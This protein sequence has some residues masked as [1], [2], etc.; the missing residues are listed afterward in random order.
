MEN[1]ADPSRKSPE[2]KN[3]P[4]SNNLVWYALAA[5]VVVLLLVGWL[6]QHT[7]N[8]LIYSDLVALIDASGPGPDARGYIDVQE[9]AEGKK[10][11]VRYTNLSEI[12]I[13]SFEVT[14]KV[15]RIVVDQETESANR[16]A[17]AARAQLQAEAEKY[18]PVAFR[19]NRSP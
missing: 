12:K 14:G 10:R 18:A 13:G 2:R 7:A 16:D 6:N 4:L 8:E 19:T 3:S 1:K 17:A 9:G 5:G 11:T 15:V